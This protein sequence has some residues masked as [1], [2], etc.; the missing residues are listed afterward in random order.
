MSIDYVSL[1]EVKNFLKITSTSHD[2]RLSNIIPM[3]CQAVETYIGREVLSNNYIEFHDGGRNS[4]FTDRIP[5]NNVTELAE[6]NGTD[7]IPLDGPSANG[8]L[9]NTAVTNT[10]IAYMWYDETGRV[11][12]LNS[13][14]K[15]ALDIELTGNPVFRNY[16]K[17]IRIQY[18]GGYDI[19]PTDIKLATLD[20]IKII[21]KDDTSET[22]SF[23]GEAKENVPMSAN[24]PPH[25]RRILEM[26]RVLM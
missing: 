2:A 25:I 19:A 16:A 9:P 23:Q 15:A 7:Y 4:I 17:G 3:I 14:G 20:Y 24:F 10:T 12:K 5:I 6:Y 22:I 18:N 21:H 8:A 11:K 26:Y 1:I 13:E